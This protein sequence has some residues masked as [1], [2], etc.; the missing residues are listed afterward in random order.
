MIEAPQLKYTSLRRARQSVLR[1]ISYASGAGDVFPSPS[2]TSRA[3]E[4]QPEPISAHANHYQSSTSTTFPS[5][6]MPEPT[7]TRSD[8]DPASFSGPP[9]KYPAITNNIL[10][11]ATTLLN[12]S[13]QTP[14]PSPQNPPGSLL[15]TSALNPLQTPPPH[16]H[17]PP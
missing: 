14:K 16:S 9:V 5:Q 11:S 4:K 1:D 8:I 7:S 10:S 2:Y 3:S 6:R 12:A 13:L 17:K 15:R